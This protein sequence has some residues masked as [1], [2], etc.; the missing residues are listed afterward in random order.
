[1]FD[2]LSSQGGKFSVI[3]L[4][5]NLGSGLALLGIVSIQIDIDILFYCCIY[6]TMCSCAF[7]L[8]SDVLFRGAW[9]LQYLISFAGHSSLW[10]CG[11]LCTPEEVFLQGEKISVGWWYWK[12]IWWFPGM[13]KLPCPAFFSSWMTKFECY[14][15]TS[16]FSNEQPLLLTV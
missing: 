9:N 7:H 2:F 1:M 16:I 13:L 6:S 3:P 10:H 11:S 15:Y 5:L 12:W 4:F 14:W 8:R